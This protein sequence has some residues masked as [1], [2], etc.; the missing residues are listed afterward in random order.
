MSKTRLVYAALLRSQAE[1]STHIKPYTEQSS[2][3]T[4]KMDILTVHCE[5]KYKELLP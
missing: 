2:Y 5:S 4:R 3:S 1:I